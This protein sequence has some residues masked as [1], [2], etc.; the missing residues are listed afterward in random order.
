MRPRRSRSAWLPLALAATLPPSAAAQEGSIVS[1]AAFLLLP[2]GARATSVGQAGSTAA[3]SSEAVFW[4]P[5]G[6]A[7]LPTSEFG[8]QYARTFATDNTALSVYLRNTR[9]GTL[10]VTAYLVDYGSQEIRPPDGGLP[11]G[12]LAPKNVELLASYATEVGSAVAL[13][14]SYKLV[15]FRQDCQGDCGALGDVTGTTHAV[16]VGAQVVIGPEEA[17]RL[18][19]VVRH[20]G[21]R[22]QLENKAQ[23]D[24]LPTQVALGVEYRLPLARLGASPDFTARVVLDLQD[25]WGEYGSPDART[26]VELAYGE[27]VFLRGGYAF[28]QAESRGASLGVGLRF[29]RFVLDLTRLFYQ[30][31]VFDDPLHV[32]LRIHL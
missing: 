25:D 14:V 29:S 16:D 31:D 7:S 17:L 8:V 24:P 1:G 26:G 5:A 13:G 6:L 19:I 20:A 21:F 10:G 28:L 32:G 22:L 18:G 9:L 11:G 15:Q 3:G 2:V 30:T 12:R 4:N 27:A 23:A